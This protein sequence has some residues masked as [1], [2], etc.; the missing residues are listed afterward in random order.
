MFRSLKNAYAKYRLIM[1]L[2]SVLS[3]TGLPLIGYAFR[4]MSISNSNS[5]LMETDPELASDRPLPNPLDW[6]LGIEGAWRWI[7][8]S[9]VALGALVLLFS[10]LGFLSRL[11]DA[12]RGITGASE[13]V[14]AAPI[15]LNTEESVS[16]VSVSPAL[17]D[18]DAVDDY[19]SAAI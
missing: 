15:N 12:Q 7:L 5:A 19:G 14:S 16:K 9:I 3:T 8:Y 18:V 13:G 17:D 6:F 4:L 11:F 1:W 2:S 10:L